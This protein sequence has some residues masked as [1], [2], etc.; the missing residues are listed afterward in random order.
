MAAVVVLA[1]TTA[2]VTVTADAGGIAEATLESILNGIAYK[3]T[4]TSP[5]TGQTRVVTITTLQDNGGTA[6]SG[7]DSVSVTI[8]ATVTVA[9]TDNAPTTVSYTHLTLPT[10]SPV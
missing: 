1:G 6:N 4:D 10:T 3:N 7:D 9:N 8:A 5:T 2:T